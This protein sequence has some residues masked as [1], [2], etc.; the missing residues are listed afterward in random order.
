MVKLLF[1]SFDFF[2]FSCNNSDEF[3]EQ[4]K[5]VRKTYNILL[6]ICMCVF[7]TFFQCPDI[8]S[9]HNL[10]IK[11]MPIKN[12]EGAKFLLYN[13]NIK[14]IIASVEKKLAVLEG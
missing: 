7:Y 8:I 12:I 10:N 14:K 1:K 9:A 11:A 2:Y 3:L 4:H 6:K 5:A 13:P